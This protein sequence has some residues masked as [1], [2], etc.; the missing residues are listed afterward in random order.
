MRAIPR[1]KTR[2]LI[3]KTR[4]SNSSAPSVFR[5]DPYGTSPLGRVYVGEASATQLSLESTVPEGTLHAEL[6]GLVSFL[7]YPTTVFEMP[8]DAIYPDETTGDTTR[9]FIGQLPYFITEMQLTWILY[10]FGGRNAVIHPERIL[11]RNVQTGERQ[12]TGCI[13]AVGSAQGLAQMAHLM[14]KRLLIDDTGVWF[15]RNDAEHGVL[16]D[17]CRAMKQDIKLRPWERPYDS[18]V[19]QEATSGSH[20]R[21]QQQ[22]QQPV[23]RVGR[24]PPPYY[25]VRGSAGAGQLASNNHNDEKQPTDAAARENDD[26]FMMAHGDN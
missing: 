7:P 1:T 26:G 25:A 12:P 17:Y 14:H 13:H 23:S 18:V 15:C 3:T 6:W 2:D 9:V 8:R 20:L 11:K 24:L 21:R 5:H 4:D 19:V 16:W 22:Q 10:T